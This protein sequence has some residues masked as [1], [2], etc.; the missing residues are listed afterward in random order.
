MY[1]FFIQNPAEALRY[2]INH[3]NERES[4]ILNALASNPNTWLS[5]M[6]LVEII[7][8]ETPEQLWIA[9]AKNVSQHLNKLKK[10]CKIE[11]RQNDNHEVVWK[12]L[13]QE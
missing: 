2:Y 9:A 13:I 8:T 1:F 5:D 7:Y 11:S 4:Q 10:E 12:Y 6:D 3:R